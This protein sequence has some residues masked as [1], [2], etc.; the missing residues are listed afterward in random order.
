MIHFY[1]THFSL[2]LYFT[3]KQSFGLHCKPCLVSISNATLQTM[4]G[5]YIECYTG[6]K[7]VKREHS[8]PQI[9]NLNLP[10]HFWGSYVNR[11]QNS[12]EN[13]KL[14]WRLRLGR[15]SV[16]Q[17]PSIGK[18]LRD[19]QH[20]MSMVLDTGRFESLWHFITKCG[21]YFITQCHRRLLQ[22]AS[23]FLL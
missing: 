16:V 7:W 12:S 22:N 4:P 8:L 15:G 9:L 18:G 10:K 1:L 11:N 3:W 19:I 5:F 2:V 21:V 6:L 14:F 13:S 23:G 17:P 20:S